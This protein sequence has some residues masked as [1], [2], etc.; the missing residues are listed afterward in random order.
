MAAPAVILAARALTKRFGETVALDRVSFELRAGEIHALCGENGA[1]KSTLIKLL[2]GVHPYGSYDG[3]FEIDG[4]EA[5]FRSVR[6]AAAAGIGVIHQE[7]SCIDELTVAENVVLGCEPRRALGFVDRPAVRRIARAALE[8]FGI[9]FD[10]DAPGGSLGVGQKQL[11]EIAKAL[12]RDSRV[13]ILDEPT[14]AL[15]AHETE[16][17]L[18]VL[19]DL[20]ARGL[21]CVYISHR[22]EEVL[23]VAD[24]VTV[25]RDGAT[26]ATFPAAGATEEQIV[27]HM[28]GREIANLYTRPPVAPGPALLEVE[29]LSVAAADGAARLTDVSFTLHAGE[30][31]GIGGLMGAGRSE[32]LM[33]LVGAYGTRTAG[34]V[35]LGGVP[36]PTRGPRA[37]LAAGLA[38]VTEDRRR[39]GLF[40]DESIGFNLTM[41]SLGAVAR[42][43][44]VDRV[45]EDARN[46]EWFASM[47]IRAPGLEAVAGRLSGG[48]QQKV[49]LGRVLMTAP[50]VVLLDEPTRGIDVGAKTEI[51]ALIGALAERG[52]AVLLVSSELP[53][54]IGLSDRIVM[55]AN[56]T[57]GGTFAR[58]EATPERLMR[59]A[60]GTRAA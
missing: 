30:V 23:A 35:V 36:A 24:R 2:S 17:L 20:R 13:L 58:T 57:V 47:A 56:G 32:L 54:L 16:V 41:S 21:A 38:L 3:R 48:N 10:L 45:R 37:A 55:L 12:S 40:L 51:Y 43:G 27:R 19:R 28:V 53:E 25:L 7:L 39:Y 46:V 31:L 4:R 52:C 60:L 8:R 14:A 6:D 44:V 18:R 50:K 5:R 26:V 11:L 49:V 9:E 1:G 59:A 42:A 22:L 34:R 15:A 29:G 33:H